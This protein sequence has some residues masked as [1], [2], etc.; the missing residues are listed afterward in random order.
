MKHLLFTLF[1]F[2]A[3]AAIVAPPAAPSKA[4]LQKQV[5]PS[6]LPGFLCSEKRNIGVPLTVNFFFRT[7]SAQPSEAILSK[8]DHTVEFITEERIKRLTAFDLER[9]H[10]FAEKASNPPVK[11]LLEIFKGIQ[12]AFVLGKEKKAQTTVRISL[13]S[14]EESSIVT[15]AFEKT[16]RGR[17]DITQDITLNISIFG[18]TTFI[19]PR[20]LNLL[21]AVVLENT[22]WQDFGTSIKVAGVSLALTG[23]LVAENA[24]RYRSDLVKKLTPLFDGLSTKIAQEI[25]TRIAAS[26]QRIVLHARSFGVDLHS[27]ENGDGPD[28]VDCKGSFL[29]FPT[30]VTSLPQEKYIDTPG[31]V[32]TVWLPLNGTFGS[33]IDG[34]KWQSPTEAVLAA[35]KDSP[36]KQIQ[37]QRV[38]ILPFTVLQRDL[39]FYTDAEQKKT[40]VEQFTK[41]L[42][43]GEWTLVVVNDTAEK[44]KK[45]PEE[46]KSLNNCIVVS[47]ALV[48]TTKP[49]KISAT[50]KAVRKITCDVAD[51]NLQQA[52]CTI[53]CDILF[54]QDPAKTMQT[55]IDCAL[56]TAT[57]SKTDKERTIAAIQAAAA[58]AKTDLDTLKA[59]AE[60]EKTDAYDK[61][62]NDLLDAQ[63]KL[64]EKPED[65]SLKAAVTI[66]ENEL[67]ETPRKNYEKA[68]AI[69]ALEEQLNA[70]LEELSHEI[71]TDTQAQSHEQFARRTLQKR[72]SYDF[73]LAQSV[74]AKLAITFAKQPSWKNRC[75]KVA[76]TTMINEKLAQALKKKDASNPLNV[77]FVPWSMHSL[78]AE[79]L[80]TKKMSKWANENNW[81]IVVVNDDVELK[82]SD[83]K[84]AATQALADFNKALV[85]STEIANARLTMKQV[86]SIYTFAS[87]PLNEVVAEKISTLHEAT[88]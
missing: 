9:N 71:V 49:A 13:D 62:K 29:G 14:L 54:A 25:D 79:T 73:K 57:A 82:D 28:A 3:C 61:A 51:E 22:F 35:H 68:Q 48:S 52:L 2:C 43:K 11:E 56:Q 63:K 24:R 27:K 72:L 32:A 36:E 5:D 16:T 20:I 12:K 70:S 67:K 88:T 18:F 39:A 77:L 42:N 84:D 7:F 34:P 4:P 19:Q 83:F 1:G 86:T 40:W 8:A 58:K 47:T 26:P 33:I 85:V 75:I 53:V 41:W 78:L 55:K 74:E 15:F 65:A 69:I 44:L 66:A 80:D 37:Q 30:R 45:Q 60:A 76:R 50:T 81:I 31:V 59:A 23:L 21:K 64:A 17:T 10:S 46:L 87:T 6:E 38:L